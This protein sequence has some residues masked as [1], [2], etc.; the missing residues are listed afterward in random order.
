M[1]IYACFNSLVFHVYVSY[2]NDYN[3]QNQFITPV[4]YSTA[5]L[6]SSLIMI[7]YTVILV[8]LLP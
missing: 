4:D 7:S 2:I 3:L 5:T 6:Y 1:L 8:F